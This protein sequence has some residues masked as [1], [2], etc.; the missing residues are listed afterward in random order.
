VA[1]RKVDRVAE[2][3]HFPQKVGTVAEALKDS[4]HLLAAR[5]CTPLIVDLRYLTGCV[6]IF[7][8]VDFRF[9][10]CHSLLQG[11]RHRNSSTPEED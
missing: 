11:F 8:D 7:D 2:A 4:G 10:V 6:R 9:R 3:H 1:F 5:L